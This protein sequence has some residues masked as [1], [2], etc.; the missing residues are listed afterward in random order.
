MALAIEAVNN[1]VNG[2]LQV[3][4]INEGAV[5]EMVLLEIAPAV[6]DRVQLRCILG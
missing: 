2:A 1:A 4:D 6:L 3:V 5:G